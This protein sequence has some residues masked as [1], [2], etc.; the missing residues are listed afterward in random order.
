[1]ALSML[2]PPVGPFKVIWHSLRGSVYCL[3]LN[4]ISVVNG[5]IDN[6]DTLRQTV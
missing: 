1:L 3:I 4:L 5:A 6:A 2:S